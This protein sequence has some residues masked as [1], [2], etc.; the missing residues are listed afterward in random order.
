MSTYY[1]PDRQQLTQGELAALESVSRAERRYGCGARADA[2][3]HE[4]VIKAVTAGDE[5]RVNMDGTYDLPRL[6]NALYVAAREAML[7]AYEKGA[8]RGLGSCMRDISELMDGMLKAL[9]ERESLEC[10]ARQYTGGVP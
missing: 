6:L 2:E 3:A 8:E 1:M 10:E 9:S 7:L 5:V 4:L